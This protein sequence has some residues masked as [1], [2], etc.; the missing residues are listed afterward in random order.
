MEFSFKEETNVKHRMKMEDFSKSTVNFSNKQ[1]ETL[2]C[3]YDGH[4]GEI[5]QKYLQRNF[6]VVYKSNLTIANKNYEEALKKTIEDLNG[7]LKEFNTNENG[8]TACIVHI[9]KDPKN[10]KFPYTI[11]SANLGDT[12]AT[13]ISPNLIKRLTFDH[14]V[15]NLNEKLKLSK[16]GQPITDPRINGEVMLSRSLGD[17]HLYKYG[18]CAEPFIQKTL[19][20]AKTK[21]QYLFIGTDGIWDFVTETDIQKMIPNCLDTEILNKSIMRLTMSRGCWDNAS[22]FV[23]R[24]T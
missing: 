4:S 3:M 18:I 2:F 23:I 15:T 9:I 24:L 19:V 10:K 7:K 17:F 12:R 16:A 13:L 5:T 11:Y 1:Y 6:E 21:F 20:S 22:L 8:S 14:R